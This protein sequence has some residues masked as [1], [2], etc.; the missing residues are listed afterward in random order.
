MTT[1]K[2]TLL[3]AA[4]LL[5]IMSAP[6]LAA[7]MD[8]PVSDVAIEGWYLRADLGWSFLDWSARDDN[9]FVGGVGAGYR[10]DENLRTDLRVDWA[11]YYDTTAGADDMTLVT[12]LGNLYFDVP[13]GTMF[14]PYVGAGAGYGWGTVDGGGDKDGFA[15]ALMAGTSVNLSEELSLDV[16]YRFRA[17]MSNGDDPME[18]QFMGGLRYEF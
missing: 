4:G 10:F 15:Y 7:D 14:T 6:S 16:G 18:H 13:T 17:I 5:A 1:F 9:E 8:A 3:A 11:G 2:R 12:A